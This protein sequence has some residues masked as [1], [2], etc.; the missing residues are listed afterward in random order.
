MIVK[1]KEGDVAELERVTQLEL[2][3]VTSRHRP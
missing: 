1:R 2:E 3:C